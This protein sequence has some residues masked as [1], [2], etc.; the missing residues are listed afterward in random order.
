MD[1]SSHSEEQITGINWQL[2][3]QLSIPQDKE[4]SW[5][6]GWAPRRERGCQDHSTA[7][8]DRP[9]WSIGGDGRRQMCVC[10]CVCVPS[11][12]WFPPPLFCLLS[13]TCIRLYVYSLVSH[14]LSTSPTWPEAQLKANWYPVPNFARRRFW[15]PRRRRR[16]KFMIPILVHK[17]SASSMAWVV[18][19]LK[20]ERERIERYTLYYKQSHTMYMYAYSNSPQTV[21]PS[22][23]QWPPDLTS[24]RWVQSHCWFIKN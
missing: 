6:Q 22:H 15:V 18:R 4:L 20:R 10:M 1:S 11:A 2:S 16:P 17:W 5:W 19:I 14:K 9:G 23:S 13:R 3:G 21:P 7:F 24:G 8:W 12:L